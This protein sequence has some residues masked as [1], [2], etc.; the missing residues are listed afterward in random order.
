MD[1]PTPRQNVYACAGL[2][3]SGHVFSHSFSRAHSASFNVQPAFC[4]VFV[5]SFLQWMRPFIWSFELNQW[6]PANVRTAENLVL[7]NHSQRSWLILFEM[8]FQVL[9]VIIFFSSFISV[10][11]YLGVMPLIISKIAWLMQIT[12]G[13]SAAESLSAA[14]NIFVG[15]VRLLISPP[16]I[17][18]TFILQRSF[19]FNFNLATL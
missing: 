18:A 17:N 8:S 2:G 4:C 7:I 15:Q 16:E 10:L 12:M 11:Y 3:I 5:C 9:T 19:A 13:T 1:R 14:G 6:F